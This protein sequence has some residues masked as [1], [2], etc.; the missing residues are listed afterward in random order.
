MI[1]E[2]L[3][4]LAFEY[5]KTKLWKIIWDSELFAVKL[6]DGRIGYISIMGCLGEHCALGLYVGEEALNSLWSLMNAH[7]FYMSPFEFQERVVNQNCLQC[8]FEGKDDLS[9][10]EREE[11]K[12]YARAHGLRISGK[13]AYPHFIKYEPG[14]YPWTLSGEKEQEDLCEALEAAIKM[15]Q[16][17]EGK[18]P[19]ELGLKRI[20]AGVQEI[21]M[22]ER[23][24]GEYVLKRTKLPEAKPVSWPKPLSCNEIGVA[25]LKKIKKADTWECEIIQYTE[26]VRNHP[27]E[28]PYF[29][30]VFMAVNSDKDYILPVDPVGSYRQNPEELLNNFIDA[31]LREKL[32]PK[33]MKVRDERTRDFV[34]IF[35]SKL[36][37]PVSIEEE[38]PVLDKVEEEFFRRFSMSEEEQVGEMLDFLSV[39]MEEEGIDLDDFPPELTGELEKI[40]QLGLLPEEV[41]GKMEELLHSGKKQGGLKKSDFK[42]VERKSNLSYVLSVSVYAGCYRHI[43][44]SGNSTLQELH[45][46]IQDAFQFEDDHAYGFFM[47]NK[48]WSDWDCYYSPGAD[49]GYRSAGKCTLDQAGLCKG[50][51][52]LY[53]FDFGD[54]WTFQCKV[55]KVVEEDTPVPM[56]LKSKGKSPEQYPNWEE[57]W[58][59]E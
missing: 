49:D 4:A 50:K 21:P 1:S 46:A 51:K 19:S 30:M 27:E 7:E 41:A 2:K 10:E 13:N 33:K 54:E 53:L 23:Q 20:D 58:E 52:F 31:L 17:L 12:A 6:S 48:R 43:Q 15:A 8:A 9:E 18:M 3:Y 36:K 42:M 56:I 47:D 29:P 39:L 25:A 34:E 35:C 44:I 59:D 38:L 45:N 5:K 22:L 55:L 57:D 28:T 37:I 16:L 32:C 40:L 11:A 26:P 24:N 14:F